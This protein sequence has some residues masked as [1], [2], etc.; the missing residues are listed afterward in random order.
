M[1]IRINL[2][3]T[4]FALYNYATKAPGGYVDVDF[5]EYSRDQ[6][7]EG[8]MI[9]TYLPYLK[10]FPGAGYLQPASSNT[11][12]QSVNSPGSGDMN[13]RS[14][15][16]LSNVPI[17]V[18]IPLRGLYHQAFIFFPFITSVRTANSRPMGT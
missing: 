5:F 6:R 2:L 1:I 14:F 11:S 3:F 13:V 16:S 17:F 8:S 9:L 18:A 4:L 12:T 7:P 10:A 15:R